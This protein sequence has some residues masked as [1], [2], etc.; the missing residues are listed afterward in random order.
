MRQTPLLVAAWLSVLA[1]A[2]FAQDSKVDDFAR[3]MFATK[4]D[5]T[6]ASACF[7]RSY[8]PAHLAR[9]RKQTVS[10]MKMLVSA[11]KVEDQTWLSYSYDL[12]IKFRDRNGDYA[13]KFFCGE[14]RMSDVRREGV[15]IYCHDGCEGGGVEI[16]LSPNAKS[17]IV[18]VEDVVVWPA[19]RPQDM[20]AQFDFKTGVGDRVF[21]L[22]RVDMENC[23]SLKKSEEVAANEAE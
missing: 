23:N 5:D 2:A 3:R 13:A 16:A 1:S 17:I 9:H 7:V 19:D 6:S 8:D 22:D 18:K 4:S 21:R 15:R 10:A 11:E 20:D 14:A 12:G